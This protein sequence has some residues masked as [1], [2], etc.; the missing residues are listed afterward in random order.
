MRSTILLIFLAAAPGPSTPT[1][2]AGSPVLSPT[3]PSPISA[4][5]C[6]QDSECE[7]TN[8]AGCC[9]C[10]QCSLGPPRAR[11][12]AGL[13]AERDRCAVTECGMGVC[14]I[15][16]MCPPGESADHFRARCVD[17][18]CALKRVAAPR[19]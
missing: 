2:D 7:V 11:T 6:S 13:R 17:G 19:H 14:A 3:A 15:A 9:A 4:E 10:P 8:F 1:V 18:R 12:R 16:G 5:M